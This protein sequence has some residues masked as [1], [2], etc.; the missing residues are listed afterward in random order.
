MA[1]QEKDLTPSTCLTAPGQVLEFEKNLQLSMQDML[2]VMTDPESNIDVYISDNHRNNIQVITHLEK[3]RMMNILEEDVK[4]IKYCDIKTIQS[5]YSQ[6]T[7]VYSNEET[8]HIQR[9]IISLI[10]TAASR[11]ISDIHITINAANTVVQFRKFKRLHHYRE[12]LR[13]FGYDLIQTLYN[14]MT[15]VADPM[16]KSTEAQDAVINNPAYLTKN[17]NGVRVSIVPTTDGWN[18]CLRLLYQTTRGEVN[19]LEQLGYNRTHLETIRKIKAKSSGILIISGPTGSGKSTT[20]KVTLEEIAKD[21]GCNDD[22]TSCEINIMTVEDPSEYKILGAKQLAVSGVETDEERMDQYHRYLKALLR[23]DPDVIMIGEIRDIISGKAAIKSAMSGHFCLTTIHTN[24]ALGILDR[25]IEMGLESANVLNTGVITGLVAQRLVPVLCQSC[26]IPLEEIIDDYN[27][28]RLERL[29]NTY[30]DDFKG[31][32]IKN[33]E[34]CSHCEN[35]GITGVTVLAEIVKTDRTLMRLYKD[36]K[37]DEAYFYW[38]NELDGITL[39]EHGLEK[40]KA[41][42]C[43]PKDVESELDELFVENLQKTGAVA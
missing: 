25:L 12:D 10:Q 16:F 27:P 2:A 36:G 26:A 35:L 43:D 13:N 23:Q 38:R 30:Q 6:K 39:M 40:I 17:L 31:I 33:P 7:S 42:I 29:R 20:L 5:F 8:S 41:G 19:S 22:G 37:T 9:D 14:Y 34:G 21:N 32:K 28:A 15:D 4:Q 1:I 11:K 18:A 3:Y 24:D